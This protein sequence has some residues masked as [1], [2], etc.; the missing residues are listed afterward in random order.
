MILELAELGQYFDYWSQIHVERAMCHLASD[1]WFIT[2][3]DADIRRLLGVKSKKLECLCAIYI[4]LVILLKTNLLTATV[5]CV[6]NHELFI[7]HL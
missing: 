1:K 7:I 2:H 4:L 5:Q 3:C 6:I